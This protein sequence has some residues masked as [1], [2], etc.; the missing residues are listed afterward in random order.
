MPSPEG[1]RSPRI[2]IA[3]ICFIAVAVAFYLNPP[4]PAPPAP[5]QPQ[6]DA[7][8][9]ASGDAESMWTEMVRSEELISEFSETIQQLAFAVRNLELPDERTRP[10][11]WPILSVTDLA[12]VSD[13]VPSGMDFS[14]ATR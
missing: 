6:S 5:V 2:L 7:L 13:A 3:S 14:L 10:L 1:R 9:S 11:F 4:A 12:S 8:P